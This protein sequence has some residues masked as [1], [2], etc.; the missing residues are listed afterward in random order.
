ME[1]QKAQAGLPAMRSW[2]MGTPSLGAADGTALWVTVPRAQS[3][4]WLLLTWSLHCLQSSVVLLMGGGIF[5][6]WL[7]STGLLDPHRP[8]ATLIVWFCEFK[9]TV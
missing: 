2:A 1:P 9:E 7:M 6:G 4:E 5:A 3:R 8:R